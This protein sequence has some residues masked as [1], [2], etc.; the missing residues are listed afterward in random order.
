M[1]NYITK[2][3]L[4]LIYQG[5]IRRG[6]AR[7]A[8]PPRHVK[9][10]IDPPRTELSHF[11]NLKLQSEEHKKISL[12]FIQCTKKIV[13]TRTRATMTEVR[14]KNLYRIH[15]HPYRMEAI[16]DSDVTQLFLN[17]KLRR[18]EFGGRKRPIFIFN[19]DLIQ[20]IHC[21]ILLFITNQ[22]NCQALPVEF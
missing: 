1:Q 7:R 14:M 20:V 18:L 10:G 9:G 6:G 12:L 22:L 21:I 5:R 3:I 13:Y 17:S 8:V 2:D 15:I 16:R 19:L 11:S 4:T